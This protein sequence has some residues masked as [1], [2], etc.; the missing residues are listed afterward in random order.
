MYRNSVRRVCRALLLLSCV[1]QWAC[2]TI[3]QVNLRGP[4]F[5]EFAQVEA[6]AAADAAARLV[7]VE[8]LPTSE[9]CRGFQLEMN[10]IL[11]A[12]IPGVRVT[13]FLTLDVPYKTF[14]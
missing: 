12:A 5:D 8:E 4:I 14:P 6:A 13:K 11:S 3:P 2:A 9:L 10:R 1:F 7:L